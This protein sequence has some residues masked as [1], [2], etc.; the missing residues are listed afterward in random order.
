MKKKKPSYDYGKYAMYTKT[1]TR[2]PQ[3]GFLSPP[4]EISAQSV[5]WIV[6]AALLY[7]GAMVETDGDAFVVTLPSG[8]TTRLDPVF[9]RPTSVRKQQMQDRLVVSL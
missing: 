3:V 2:D 8:Q 5:Q 4:T 9:A 6:E 1:I 7:T